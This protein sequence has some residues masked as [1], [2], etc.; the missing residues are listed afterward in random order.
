[1]W[2]QGA[3]ESLRLAAPSVYPLYTA[4]SLPPLPVYRLMPPTL[5]WNVPPLVDSS[6]KVLR[7]RQRSTHLISGFRLQVFSSTRRAQADS[8][9]FYLLET[10]PSMPVYFMYEVPL[11]K[12]RVGDFLDRQQAQQQL[13]LLRLEFPSAFI[14]PDQ[15][16]KP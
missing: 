3:W 4:E 12:I 7:H 14:V 6:Y 10:Y 16:P 13:E 15:I 8:V 5:R 11:Y 2:A 9:K 1:M